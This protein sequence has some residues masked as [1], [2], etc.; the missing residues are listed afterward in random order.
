MAG[1]GDSPWG[2]SQSQSTQS[3]SLHRTTLMRGWHQQ[4]KS[5]LGSTWFSELPS[6]CW[7]C[8]L[9]SR[10]RA[11]HDAVSPTMRQAHLA[12]AA[13]QGIRAAQHELSYEHTGCERSASHQPRC[14]LFDPWEDALGM[15]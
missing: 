5:T 1:M 15:T 3:S 13:C 8:P 4:Q 12:Q 2:T 9:S 11:W 14:G 6:G 7:C 10:I